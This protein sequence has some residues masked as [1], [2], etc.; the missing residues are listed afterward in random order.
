M[1]RL[2]SLLPFLPLFDVENE[3]KLLA[4]VVINVIERLWPSLASS[5][6]IQSS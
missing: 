4:L 3:R 1:K 5:T 6:P 2:S